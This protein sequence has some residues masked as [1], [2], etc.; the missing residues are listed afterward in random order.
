MGIR[1]HQLI[2]PSVVCSTHVARRIANQVG[3]LTFAHQHGCGIIGE[4]VAGID[5]FFADLAG[6]PNVSSVLIVGL[7][8]ET[9]QA[10]ELA[11]KLFAVNP[12]T[13]FQIIQE[14][15]GVEA[16]VIAGVEAARNLDLQ[17]PKIETGSAKFKVGLD[18]PQEDAFSKELA[19]SISGLGLDVIVATHS[20]AS[21]DNFSD[22]MRVG[23]HV[24]V[25][26]PSGNQPASGFPL[27]PV[28]NISS[29]S[30]LH[31]A[32]TQDFDLGHDADIPI[33]LQ[34]LIST[35][36]GTLTKAEMNKMGEIRAPRRVRSV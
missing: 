34:T 25:S 9:I 1:H 8:C 11:T 14:S 4:D 29:G 10:Q 31:R 6:H 36:E 7:G 3:A 35:I 21:I 20:A 32:T 12:S 13:K 23:T 30:G 27:I 26:R 16:T 28:I 5:D 17:F 24:I 33:I 18:L 19:S 22:F 15:G 2:L